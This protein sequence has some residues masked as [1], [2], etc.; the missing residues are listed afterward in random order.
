MLRQLIR[1]LPEQEIGAHLLADEG[2]QVIDVVRHHWIVYSRSVTESLI[3]LLLWVCAVVGPIQFGWLF[4][5][6]GLGVL[7]HAAWYTLCQH[8]DVFV[9]T[10]MR[11]FRARGVL[12]VRVATVPIQRILD[13][14]VDKPLLG[15]LSG[16]GHIIFESAAQKQGMRDIRYIGDPDG[17]DLTIQRVVQRSGLRGPRTA[18]DP[19]RQAY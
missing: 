19:P 7:I 15:R 18:M 4:L 17:R 3:A 9:I 14:T 11:V 16:Y 6:A 10:N 8:M 2:E 5:L 1:L 12:S 13:I